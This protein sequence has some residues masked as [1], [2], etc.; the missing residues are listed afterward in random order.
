[1]SRERVSALQ[2]MRVQYRFE[3]MIHEQKFTHINIIVTSP[4][5]IGGESRTDT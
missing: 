5:N 2:K 3:N 4:V 1:M